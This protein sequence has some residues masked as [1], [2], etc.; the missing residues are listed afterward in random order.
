MAK[1]EKA[2][3]QCIDNV[4]ADLLKCKKDAEVKE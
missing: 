4:S 3:T 1:A 2:G